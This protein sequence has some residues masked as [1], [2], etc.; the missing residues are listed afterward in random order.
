MENL[1]LN[2]SLKGNMCMLVKVEVETIL[3]PVLTQVVIQILEELTCLGN[4]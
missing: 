2:N 3:S 1:H 4:S